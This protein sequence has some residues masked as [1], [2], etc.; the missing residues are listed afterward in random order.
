M[1]FTPSL[2]RGSLFSLFLPFLAAAAAPTMLNKVTSAAA[3]KSFQRERAGP[4]YGPGNTDPGC[5]PGTP[6]TGS[7]L[8]PR[9]DKSDDSVKRDSIA[10]AEERVED[11]TSVSRATRF[12]PMPSGSLRQ[13]LFQC[14]SRISSRMS[15][16]GLL[17]AIVGLVFEPLRRSR[18]SR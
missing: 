6:G 7:D 3:R 2:V 13:K 16:L 9:L 15:A 14:S 8:H 1:R 4:V 17:R 5:R 18:I 11:A 12:A 10:S